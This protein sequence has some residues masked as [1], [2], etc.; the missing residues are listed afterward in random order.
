MNNYEV[1]FIVRPDADE[2]IIKGTI[3][4]VSETV[5]NLKGQ[6]IKTEEWGKQLYY[7]KYVLY[8]GNL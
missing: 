5:G 3:Q 2:N 8:P 6:I 1:V 7:G 4:K